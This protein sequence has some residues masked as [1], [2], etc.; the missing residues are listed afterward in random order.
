MIL[1]QLLLM[2]FGRKD[3][4]LDKNIPADYLYSMNR[5]LFSKDYEV[6][7]FLV[8]YQNR[9]GL[10]ALLNL[11]QDAAILHAQLLGFGYEDMVRMKTFWVLTRQ[12]LWMKSWPKSQEKVTVKTWIREGEGAFSHRDFSIHLGS[13][14]IGE[15]TTSW[16]TL[17]AQ[18][19]RPVIVDRS[20]MLSQ[21]DNIENVSL[22]AKKLTAVKDLDSVA[23]FKVRNSDIDQN[24]H[25]NN[26]KYAQ[27][28]LDS[29]ALEKHSNFK[30]CGYEVNFV[31][32]TKMDD[33]ITIQKSS[34]QEKGPGILETHFQG[35]RLSDDKMVFI[36]KLQ[37][38]SK[39]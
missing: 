34:P 6:S 2:I 23:Q 20:A 26:T 15:C 16:V 3:S 21:L 39:I 13:E 25:V 11:L 7:S 1:M 28:I 27:W 36:A 33:L 24:M 14:K 29:I 35:Q 12:N 8:N 32:E 4:L 9:L 31:A 30:L 17:D 19:R 18:S 10:Y 37:F 5:S 38:V 22:V